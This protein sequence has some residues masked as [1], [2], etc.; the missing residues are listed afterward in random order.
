MI[1]MKDSS[2]NGWYCKDVRN[3]LGEVICEKCGF[4]MNLPGGME[5]LNLK[6]HDCKPE[7]NYKVKG[8]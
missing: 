5:S 2:F 6:E 4:K 8:E 7:T 1:T 3:G